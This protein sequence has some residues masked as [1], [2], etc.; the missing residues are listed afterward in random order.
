MTT[1]CS[2]TLA[3]AVRRSDVLRVCVSVCVQYCC[4]T[5]RGKDSVHLYIEKSSFLPSLP[6]DNPSLFCSRYFSIFFSF[7]FFL[8]KF[9]W[10]CKQIK[11]LTVFTTTATATLSP[12]F[13]QQHHFSCCF[14]S[15]C[16]QT[17]EEC[18]LSSHPH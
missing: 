5:E 16:K 15:Y 18:D 7:S 1:H 9:F 17:I 11:K 12:S 14:S 2:P 10:C 6:P 4:Q 3:P 13:C 8:E